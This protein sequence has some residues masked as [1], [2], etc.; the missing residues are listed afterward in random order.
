M[1]APL[2]LIIVGVLILIG[3]LIFAF[4][5]RAASRNKALGRAEVINELDRET[6]DAT[7]KAD[8]V[9][10]EHRTTGDTVGKLRDGS[11]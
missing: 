2:A 3:T 9:L 1:S 7:R 6:I 8:V 5:L 10:S 11:F 4:V